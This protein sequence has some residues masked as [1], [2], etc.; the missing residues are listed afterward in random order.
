MLLYPTWIFYQNSKLLRW[1]LKLS[2]L[3]FFVEHRPGSKMGHVDALS[4][5][6]G[7]TIQENLLDEENV[8]R[9]QAKDAFCSKQ[10]PGTYRSKQEFFLDSD[11]ILYKRKS[12]GK[13]QLIVPETLISEVIKENHNPVYIP[14]PRTKRTYD[15][16]SLRYWWPGMRKSIEDYI[17]NC[18]LCQRRNGDREFVAPLRQTEE[19]MTPNAVT[20]MDVTGPYLL[21]QQGN[22]YLVTFIDQFSRYVEAFPVPDQTAKTLAHVY[23]TQIVTRHGTG[24]NWLHIKALPSCHP[25]SRKRKL[26]GIRRT[27]TT[28]YHPMPNG[29]SERLHR[30]LHTGLSHYINSVNTNWDTLVP[31]FLMAYLFKGRSLGLSIS[32]L[33]ISLIVKCCNSL[34][35]RTAAF[36]QMP[37]PMYAIVS[38]QRLLGIYE[39]CDFLRQVGMG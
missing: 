38:T 17:K 5:H 10:S 30:S 36:F 7:T 18:D 32:H 26:L 1:S 8:R 23:A 22:R 28:S 6:V 4:C 21:T 34:R 20:S 39:C 16:I 35:F 13:H 12:N 19:P 9:E 27:R 24:S 11:G 31:F 3:D 2:E 29:F 25:F 37:L 15:L 33:Y 14:H